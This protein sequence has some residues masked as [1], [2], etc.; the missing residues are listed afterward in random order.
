MPDLLNNDIQYMQ[1]AIAKLKQDETR[2]PND[3]AHDKQEEAEIQQLLD[4]LEAI[5]KAAPNC[6]ADINNIVS[7]LNIITSNSN[8]SAENFSQDNLNAIQGAVTSINASLADLSKIAATA[9]GQAKTDIE[10]FT[11]NSFWQGLNTTANTLNTDFNNPI[12]IIGITLPNANLEGDIQSLSTQAT[13]GISSVV[14]PFSQTLYNDASTEVQNAVATL[15][16]QID[17]AKQSVGALL[18][19][20][21]VNFSHLP[22]MEQAVLISNY[23]ISQMNTSLT[24]RLTQIS[25][26]NKQ[27]STYNK[28]LQVCK[29]GTTLKPSQTYTAPASFLRFINSCINNGT[30]NQSV[31]N[32][33]P[34]LTYYNP[35]TGKLNYNSTWTTIGSGGGGGQWAAEQTSI[36]N[37]IQ[38]QT[39]SINEQMDFVQNTMDQQSNAMQ[40]VSTIIQQGSTADTSVTSAIGAV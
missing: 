11:T 32:Q 34:G 17:S 18:K 22:L 5:H 13:S 4:K 2:N 1:N 29:N 30:L 3:V 8:M 31:L 26:E 38:D 33:L 35:T 37:L 19:G 40:M 16:S 24:N 10:N 15:Q 39:T 7:Q 25:Q 14:T 21:P 9:T 23:S 27:L 6:N 12:K 28:Y 20:L 36:Q